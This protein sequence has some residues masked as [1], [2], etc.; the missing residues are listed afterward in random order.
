MAK[1]RGRGRGGE[2]GGGRAADGT[3]VDNNINTEEGRPR[4]LRDGLV[5]EGQHGV[6]ARRPRLR[7]RP[8][9]V[10]RQVSLMPGDEELGVPV[11]GGGEDGEG[12]QQLTKLLWGEDF[13][14]GYLKE[15]TS[16]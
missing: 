14:R 15:M 2:V 13:N 12:R 9:V 7:R 8:G 5:V 16:V 6:E 4:T 1:Q 11:A 10:V 3:L